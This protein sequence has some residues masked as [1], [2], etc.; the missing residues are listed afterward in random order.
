MRVYIKIDSENRITAVK[1]EIFISDTS[2]W[3]EIDNG[4]GVR[5]VHAQGN[6]L[7]KPITDENGVYRYKFENGTV[8]ERSADEMAADMPIPEPEPPTNAELAQAIAELA[9]VICGG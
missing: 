7:P 9:E 1:S 2:D 5:F 3:V 8:C 6:Y 4:D